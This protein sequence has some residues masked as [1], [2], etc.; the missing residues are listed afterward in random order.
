MALNNVYL[1]DED[2]QKLEA[3]QQQPVSPA[4][5]DLSALQNKISQPAPVVSDIQEE[6]SVAALVQKIKE[7]APQKPTPQQPQSNV[8]DII[9]KLLQ[10]QSNELSQAKDTRGNLQLLSMLGRAGSTAG[11][12]LSPL[13]NIKPDDSFYD[14]LDKQA[15]QPVSDIENKQKLAQG[16]VKTQVETQDLIKKMDAADANSDLSKTSREI[17]RQTAAFAKLNIP[18]SDNVSATDLE[19]LIPGIEG[20]A[21]KR[22]LK[23]QLN[24]N[25]EL[26]FDKK[27]TDKESQAVAQ[28]IQALESAR[29]NPEVQQALKDRYSASKALGLIDKYDPNNLSPS[30]V[31]LIAAEVSK[32]A[33][34][35][36]PS[37]SEM[38]ALSPDTFRTR[39]G[40]YKSLFTN[41]P[42]PAEAAA[43]VKQFRDYVSDL[44]DG[45]EDVVDTKTS[46]VLESNKK[47]L[48]GD[49]YK[50][51]KE[52]YMP[53]KAEPKDKGPTEEEHNEAI[54]WAKA[55]SQD[56]RS[57]SI[58]QANGM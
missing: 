20:M 13:G 2:R 11:A 7:V 53:E 1:S 32:I 58:L 35:G 39:F 12:A 46:R 42:E 25:R 57:A 16:A 56:P 9:S 8:S 4:S 24:S 27:A 49:N 30:Q 15:L 3:M 50:T 44:K 23:D 10:N 40:K 26:A 38:K 45:A 28:T 34:G 29:G 51:L 48:G 43:F 22:I 19:K 33:T 47:R 18:I 14:A 55:N 5:V 52:Q 41:K 17:A 6:P 36:V 31:H 54:K 21:N 37:V